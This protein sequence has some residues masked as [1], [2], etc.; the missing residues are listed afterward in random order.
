MN[1]VH[2]FSA[3]PCILPQEVLQEASMAA[4]NFDNLGLS[5]LEISHRSKSFVAVMTE[6][7]NLVREMLTIP[8][9]Y[10]VLFLQG[11][12]SLGFLISAYTMKEE[13]KSAQY[14]D[15]G[16][17]SKKAIKEAKLIQK[18]NVLAS[19]S[20]SNYSYIPKDYEIPVDGSYLH[21]TSNNTIFGTQ[22]K[23]FPKSEIPL[24]ADMSSDIFS[25]KLNVSDFELIYA[26]AQKNLG[27]AGSTIYIV[28][29]ETLEKISAGTPSMLNL[30]IQ[31]AKE[32]MFNTPPVFSIYVAM[33]NLRYMLKNGG[34]SH[35]ET[36]AKTRA[37][38]IYGEIDRN[39]LFEGTCAIEDRS[40]M[41]TTFFLK[42]ESY[43]ERFDSLLTDAKISG[44]NGHRSVGGYRAS[45]YNALPIESVEIVIDCMKKIE[46]Y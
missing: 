18:V 35:Y 31:A 12:A 13:G 40:N 9:D 28:K 26:G 46:N 6:A 34:L 16:S 19:S 30:Q 7:Q 24:V 5:I 14:L 45:M 20:D 17:W 41:N 23:T 42:D 39:E 1:K 44:L 15:T 27:P 3:G 38:M 8:D 36:L 22:Y 33:L 37:D 25:R 4:T 29:K 11:G 21:F 32:S 2:N 43:K 10:D